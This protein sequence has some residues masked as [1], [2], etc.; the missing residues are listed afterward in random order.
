MD[1]AQDFP[2][3]Y[4]RLVAQLTH[5]DKDKKIYFAYDEKCPGTPV[6]EVPEGVGCRIGGGRCRPA[7]LRSG[8]RGSWG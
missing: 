8:D 7:G 5:G 6:T 2:Q 3:E 1:E 4:F